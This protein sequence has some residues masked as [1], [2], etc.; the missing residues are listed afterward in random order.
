MVLQIHNT[1]AI[2]NQSHRESIKR[3]EEVANII[4]ISMM[5]M[6]MMTPGWDDS[7]LHLLTPRLRVRV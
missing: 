3:M 4:M 6:I 5:I 1:T 7:D 2:S